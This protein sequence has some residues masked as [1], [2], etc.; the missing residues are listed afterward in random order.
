MQEVTLFIPRVLT[1]V[2]RKDITEYFINEKIGYCSHIKSKY[3][4]N[5]KG[6]EYWFAF[7]TIQFFDTANARIFYKKVVEEEKVISMEYFDEILQ[8]VRYWEISLRNLEKKEIAKI[9]PKIELEEG[10]ICETCFGEE[11]HKEIYD[12][13][14]EIEREIFSSK[15]VYV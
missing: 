5:A 11:E 8:Q 10:E 13:Y 7:I 2:S 1:T 14:L 3:R 12:D 4:I 6:F 15:G 9:A